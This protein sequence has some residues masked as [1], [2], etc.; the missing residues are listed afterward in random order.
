MRSKDFWFLI[1]PVV[2]GESGV[3]SENHRLTEKKFLLCFILNK[4][5]YR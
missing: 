4:T 1:T 3:T 2:V 5:Q